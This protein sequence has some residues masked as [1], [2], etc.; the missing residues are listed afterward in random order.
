MAGRLAAVEMN[1]LVA[2][3]ASDSVY[4]MSQQINEGVEGGELSREKRGPTC[5][6]NGGSPPLTAD[7]RK[8]MNFENINRY[9]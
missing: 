2:E 4:A 9:I 6:Q 7:T 3:C 5:R 8:E 1:R